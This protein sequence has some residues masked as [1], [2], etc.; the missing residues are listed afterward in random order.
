VPSEK[1]GDL[2]LEKIPTIQV[3]RKIINY[4]LTLRKDSSRKAL[5]AKLQETPT[6]LFKDISSERGCLIAA[7]LK[8]L[9]AAA[10][11]APHPLEEETEPEPPPVKS[12][13]PPPSKKIKATPAPKPKKRGRARLF[14]L[15][16]L[17]IIFAAFLVWSMFSSTSPWLDLFS[18]VKT[19][20]AGLPA[21]ESFTFFQEKAR[22]PSIL[23]CSPP[24]LYNTFL[25]QYRLRP[26]FRFIR[27]FEILTER[28]G[29][30][31]ASQ[32]GLSPYKTGEILS[33]GKEI[34]I[35][36]LKEQKEI[37]KIKLL[38]PLSFSTVFPALG[39]W[40]EAMEGPTSKVDSPLLQDEDAK[41]LE[42]ADQEIN[43]LDPRF[44][45]F[46]LRK[47]E[48]LRGKIGPDSRIFRS[49]A[50]AYALLGLV[51]SPDPL[52]GTDHL[53][54]EALTCLALARK[55]DPT[56]PL[57][58]EEALLALQ[59]GYRAH[60]QQLLASDSPGANQSESKIF[61]AFIRKDFA[62]LKALEGTGNRQLASYL[63]SRLSREISLE[64]EAGQRADRLLEEFP[65]FYPALAEILLSGNMET[66]KVLAGIYPKD[67]LTHLEQ[68]FTSE[69]VRDEKNWKERL[70]SYPPEPPF[71]PLSPT[72]FENLLKKWR[73]LGENGSFGLLVDERRVKDI[74]R[75]LYT[76]ALF[77]RFN[78]YHSRGGGSDLAQR[79]IEALAA[80]DKEHP[81]I[82]QMQALSLNKS[83]KIKEADVLF[84]RVVTQ[85]TIS[86]TLLTGSYSAINDFITRLTLLRSASQKLD[87]R[88]GHLFF[89]GRA[90][91]T[92]F[93]LD[94]AEKFFFSG[95]TQDP[96]QSLPYIYLA[97]ATGR[98]DHLALALSKYGDHFSLLEEAGNYYAGRNDPGS[99]EKALKYL[100]MALK[101]APSKPGLTLEKIKVLKQLNR[102]EEAATAIKNWL[103]DPG[104][105]EGTA[106][107]FKTQLADTYLEL[108]K[109]KQAL[110]VLSKDLPSNQAETL[111]GAARAYEALGQ[112]KQADETYKKIAAR[113]AQRE[114]IIAGTA[115]YYWRQGRDEEAAVLII[116][117][118]KTIKPF[119]SWVEKDFP[120]VFGNSPVERIKKAVTALT[121]DGM[122]NG[123]ISFLASQFERR[124]RP[125][126]AFMLLHDFQP[127]AFGGRL[128]HIITTYNVLKGWRGETEASRYLKSQS[129]SQMKM[130]L[131]MIL[132]RNGAFDQIFKELNDPKSYP[133]S[134][135]EFFWLQ[136]LIAW[137]ALGK[138]PSNLESQFNDHYKEK[139]LEKWSGNKDS[140]QYHLIGQFLLGLISRQNFLG[141][142]QTPKQRCLFAYFIGLSERLKSNFP[143]ATI[144]YHLA[145]ETLFQTNEEFQRAREELFL[146][147]QVGSKN[148]HRLW[149]DDREMGVQTKKLSGFLSPS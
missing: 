100:E 21:A 84:S 25:H 60:A 122:T 75:T 117:G 101:M 14:L 45:L 147:S 20:S 57:L 113:F 65:S 58:R 102:L 112:R 89:M 116:Q 33:N 23:E 6:V 120:E 10:F 148:R 3:E 128:E 61:G 4:L 80:K 137:Q 64:D 35:P 149:R 107:L 29:D 142:I 47:L 44:I 136:R 105:P 69:T 17:L 53:A 110:E 90:F 67:I 95:L 66:A 124:K 127:T 9:G 93:N 18:G 16:L 91:Q 38:L 111:L 94:L 46:A 72:Q 19:P 73:P 146:W 121:K 104:R 71:A 109:P 81:L 24:D 43:Q 79:T 2:V 129:S 99:K 77:L 88:P 74:F 138:K 11:F 96:Y 98:D 83:G 27:A 28:F 70:K 141:Q 126:V 133:S 86:G 49:A 143:E 123:E 125:D 132:S 36:L 106:R 85:S 140:D 22:N 103:K 39:Q 12:L 82:L 144:W 68:G 26:D 135:R 41:V 5:A 119:S 8:A 92:L 1:R 13:K 32:P 97:Q 30:Y 37:L 7:E 55:F 62:G 54:S 130:P 56:L 52:D 139:W 108:K 59:M 115:A 34:L 63:L 51:L 114:E 42:A 145:L 31:R 50:R 40:L 15:I 78:L 118:R 48:D 131:I 134:Q 76:G 87:G